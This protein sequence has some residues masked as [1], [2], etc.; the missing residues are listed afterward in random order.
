[1]FRELWAALGTDPYLIAECAVRPNLANR[2][3]RNSYAHD[4]RFHHE[5]KRRT[6]ADLRVYSTASQMQKMSGEYH[7]LTWLKEKTNGP[8]ASLSFPGKRGSAER[9]MK[10]QGGGGL[11][12]NH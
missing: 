1:M 9:T 7:E 2:L 6:E 10:V 3:I 11:R 8:A 4:E 12:R 5:V